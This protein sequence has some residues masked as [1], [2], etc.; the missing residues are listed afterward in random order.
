MFLT[1]NPDNGDY[2]V[3]SMDV[4]QRTRYVNVSLKWDKEPWAE[5][6]EKEGIDSRCINFILLN[7]DICAEKKGVNARSLTNF[8]NSISSVPVFE[9]QLPLIQMMG[10]GSVGVEAS[11]LFTSFI[12]GKLD[13]LPSPDQMMTGE[14]KQI[15]TW[16]TE[17]VG[18]RKKNHDKYRAD[19]ASTLCTRIINWNIS[20]AKNI[21]EGNTVPS[22]IIGRIREITLSEIFPADLSY[23]LVRTI[24][25]S[26]KK[27]FA[28]LL[29][30]PKLVEYIT[31]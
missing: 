8:F 17:V 19:I 14:S 5:W 25:N 6:A 30:D 26:D 18:E 1:E 16:M 13:K 7:P 29:V 23:R 9:E 20:N 3:T 10:E 11:T 27:K 21:K 12:I 22:S 4:A 28:E 2:S 24:F 15:L 31:K